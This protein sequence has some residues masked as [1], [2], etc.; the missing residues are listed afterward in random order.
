M[1]PCLTQPLRLK[2]RY[3]YR[4]TDRVDGMEAEHRG[5]R[6]GPQEN[7]RR[8]RADHG[9][10]GRAPLLPPVS[11]YFHGV[12]DQRVALPGPAP[13]SMQPFDEFGSSCFSSPFG[14]DTCGRDA[15]S[16]SPSWS[17]SRSTLASW[18]DSSRASAL[19]SP[20]ETCT[21]LR[22]H[23]NPAEVRPRDANWNCESPQH[24]IRDPQDP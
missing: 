24:E 6:G 23:Y 10:Q 5:E 8:V 2:R 1:R 17:A 18:W 12:G 22:T 15:T 3:L 21:P 9:A 7:E 19:L 11:D 16:P 4:Y 20:P 14:G 13:V